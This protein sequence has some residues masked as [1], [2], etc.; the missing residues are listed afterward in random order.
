M[1]RSFREQG[2]LTEKVRRKFCYRYYIRV[3]PSMNVYLNW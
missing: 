2:V 1:E 3:T